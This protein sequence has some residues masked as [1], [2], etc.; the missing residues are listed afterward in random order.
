MIGQGIQFDEGARIAGPLLL[1]VMEAEDCSVSMKDRLMPPS[2]TTRVLK[3]LL[4]DG[5][6]MFEAVEA[7]PCGELSSGMPSGCKIQLHNVELVA[8]VFLMDSASVKYFGGGVARL[9]AE[10]DRKW[11]ERRERFAFRGIRREAAAVVAADIRSRHKLLDVG[12]SVVEVRGVILG[13]LPP[14]AVVDSEFVLRARLDDGSCVGVVVLAGS[15]VE[16]II[17]MAAHDFVTLDRHSP[18]DGD[19]FRESI[20]LA[21]ADWGTSVFRVRKNTSGDVT[22]YDR[23]PCTAEDCDGAARQAHTV[24]DDR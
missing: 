20:A 10:C 11:K 24:L 17:H 6:R 7:Q 15:I 8:G 22:V 18:D 2:S 3:L 16:G 1:Q 5:V 19:Q 9:Q 13:L 4:T 14:V 12:G 21:V 23:R